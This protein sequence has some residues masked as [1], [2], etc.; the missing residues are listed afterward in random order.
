MN[1]GKPFAKNEYS[2]KE[3]DIPIS[4]EYKLDEYMYDGITQK[5]IMSD[6]L[7]IHMVTHTGE[8]AHKY[9][10]C[11][12]SFTRSGA[13]KLHMVTHTWEILLH[14]VLHW[15]P[16][17]KDLKMLLSKFLS[18]VQTLVHMHAC[19]QFWRVPPRDHC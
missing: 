7:N 8:R 9:G 15:L 5:F 3:T 12:K 10:H 6:Q 13:L 4:K 2:D 17:S 16:I 19:I 11:G 1:E 18:V 14:D